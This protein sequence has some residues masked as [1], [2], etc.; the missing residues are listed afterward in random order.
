MP[1]RREIA[2]HLQKLG[3]DALTA[4]FREH[5]HVGDVALVRRH[6]QPRVAHHLS[7]GGIQRRQE[8]GAL[9]L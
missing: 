5:R 6:Q 8:G 9:V 3:G 1:A 4:V 7:R 2:E